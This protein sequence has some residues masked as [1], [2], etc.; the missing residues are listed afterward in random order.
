MA[1]EP[2]G[3]PPVDEDS[4]AAALKRPNGVPAPAASPTRQK[5]PDDVTS[6]P[7]FEASP[8]RRPRAASD[9]TSQATLMSM[10][11]SIVIFGATGDLA[12]TTPFPALYQLVLLGQLRE[13]L[14]HLPH[15]S[16]PGHV[17]TAQRRLT[18]RRVS[19]VW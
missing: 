17:E 6:E 16:Q 9:L 4:P 18:L 2:I 11:L 8:A 10:P 3:P 13:A 5:S 1:A 15:P 7:F 14:A 19:R 12:T